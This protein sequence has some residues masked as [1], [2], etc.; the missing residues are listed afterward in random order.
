MVA[1][2]TPS[3]NAL[4][5]SPPLAIR[6]AF[7][8]VVV[9]PPVPAATA[10]FQRHVRCLA[11]Q[12]RPEFITVTSY[13]PYFTREED[14]L[15]VGDGHGI[16]SCGVGVG[17][18]N[19]TS[20]FSSSATQEAIK[21][22]LA[23]TSVASS[24]EGE[25]E[26]GYVHGSGE[27]PTPP[28][29]TTAVVLTV[30]ATRSTF[31]HP[32]HEKIND[33][34]TGITTTSGNTVKQ[35]GT[36]KMR[37]GPVDSL[38]GATRRGIA[39]VARSFHAT[40]SAVG[41]TNPAAAAAAAT[42]NSHSSNSSSSMG[43]CCCCSV[44]GGLMI[45][46]GDDG[47]CSRDACLSTGGSGSCGGSG[48]ETTTPSPYGGDF[49]DGAALFSF[50]RKALARMDN[51]SQHQHRQHHGKDQ[52]REAS[53]HAVAAAAAAPCGLLRLPPSARLTPF[54]GGY[55]QGHW[56]EKY[57][58]PP[59]AATAADQTHLS[60][61]TTSIPPPPLVVE[62][63]IITAGGDV[64]TSGS[65][66]EGE[67]ATALQQQRR[68]RSYAFLGSLD[69]LL[70]ETNVPRR[71]KPVDGATPTTADGNIAIGPEGIITSSSS[72]RERESKA[73]LDETIDAAEKLLRRVRCG[74]CR[75]YETP[76]S[77][78]LLHAAGAISSEALHT[79]RE[80]EE[81]HQ[82]SHDH[83]GG[84][85]CSTSEELTSKGSTPPLAL[86][87]AAGGKETEE[88]DG[89]GAMREEKEAPTFG[90]V[91]S[92]SPS[93]SSTTAAEAV[94]LGEELRAQRQGIR[95]GLVSPKLGPLS[96]TLFS[97]PQP[98]S[99]SSSSCAS[100]M[101]RGAVVVTQM[102]S[103]A[104]E[105]T[106]YADLVHSEL[107]TYY[108]LQ[109]QSQ[110]HPSDA[111]GDDINSNGTTADVAV[112]VVP[113]L[114][115]PLPAEDFV[116][117]VLM[118]RVVPSPQLYWQLC[119]Y[120]DGIEAAL[121]HVYRAGDDLTSCINNHHDVDDDDD[122]DDDNAKGN[123]HPQHHHRHADVD[124]NT[125]TPESN[126][127]SGGSSATL[128]DAVASFHRTKAALETAFEAAMEDE[129][130]ACCRA[131]GRRGYTHVNL[132]C[133]SYGCGPAVARV[134]RRLRNDS[135]CDGDW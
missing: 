18:T 1:S 30:T 133:F 70:A 130:V 69:A 66:N 75:L 109:Q 34:D 89:G 135:V 125:N 7:S 91:Q 67:R 42:V 64:T 78:S 33:N 65:E 38:V 94:Y 115:A 50:C 48:G 127:P 134:A 73:A 49:S 121:A 129:C 95:D 10:A 53:G 22:I 83:R 101:D 97:L 41:C 116:R 6:Y 24:D 28:A 5:L 110:S 112:V 11:G 88:E 107:A 13:S 36:R 35:G 17:P 131:L 123:Q 51:G 113:G 8:C 132:S 84:G 57:W 61:P 71:V 23:C 15:A 27:P 102:V 54:T 25:G 62:A 124:N 108:S 118:Q 39:A 32:A 37:E 86:A 68:L 105:F 79:L 46:R 80:R 52:V 63:D 81:Q 82:Q 77:F 72:E 85:N 56:L 19:S 122:G 29:P 26:G 55:P 76:S 98:S 74:A 92:P 103:S 120:A 87:T 100:A 128:V 47:G 40:L 14:E 114:M 104:E 106:R 119:A 12:L 2:N 126:K 44:V 20:T 3:S 60:N 117:T 58:W 4:I 45:L 9:P 59:A 43:S 99:S 21:Y 16:A 93:S 31:A 96:E 90:E 111:A